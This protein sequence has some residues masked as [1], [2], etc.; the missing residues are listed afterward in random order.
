MTKPTRKLVSNLVAML[1][2]WIAGGVAFAAPGDW[3]THR[4]NPQRT[5]HIDG[6]A[7][8]KTPKVL[9]VHRST[10]H[11]L[12]PPA[13]GA[14]A[15]YVS[16]LGALNTSSFHALHAAAGAKE[17]VAWSKKTPYLK[18]PVAS[19]PAIAG[20]LL[21]FGDGMHQTNSA[22]LHCLRADSGMMVWQLPLAGD[23]VHLEGA[24]TI[25][26]GK[27]Y[28]GGGNAG[29]VCVDINRMTLEGK[30]L[31][32][33]AVKALLDKRWK[34][35]LAKYEVEKKKDP[36]F[37]VPPSEDSLPKPLPHKLWQQ[38]K[39]KW[40]VDAAVN[41]VDGKVL[42]ASAFLDDERV[43]E[44]AIYCLS[45]ADGSTLWQ[46]P[47][48]LNPWGGASVADGLAVVGCSSIRF[49]T[50]F[51]PQAQGEIVALSLAD[52][53]PRWQRKVAGGVVSSV[54]LQGSLGVF[55]ATDGK[56]RAIQLDK[57]TLKWTYDARAGF[58][59]GP[60]VTA[61][62]IYVADL[63]GVVHALNLSD[64]RRLWALDLANDPAVK[65]P[66]M[67]YGS[68]IVHDGRLY[69]A[70]SNVEGERANKGTVVVCIGEK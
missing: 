37:A 28:V 4:G 23:L 57:G 8:P 44:R 22:V 66:G 34:E 39:E 27:V 14:N 67:V 40:H 20:G 7:G 38:G 60:A 59:A 45:A 11:F 49:D 30:E 21:V 2:I 15:V 56:V 70:T 24:P 25:A 47:L 16:A 36:D 33:A 13:A 62:T 68:P 43:G 18:M 10:E 58:F 53:K 19:T 54:A 26:A 5:G 52:G 9:W 65:A 69:V 48:K 17:Q 29:V 63:Q 12:A 41:V 50:K 51:I 31:D 6:K 1:P 61:D 64:G 55:T 35:L 42:A 32:V 46:A 3:P